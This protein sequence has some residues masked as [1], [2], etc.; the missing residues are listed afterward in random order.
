[1]PDVRRPDTDMAFEVVLLVIDLIS[2]M[3]LCRSP[4]D[5][6]DVDF[7]LDVWEATFPATSPEGALPK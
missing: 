3:I 5:L 4:V 2:W 6:R 1:M 7:S